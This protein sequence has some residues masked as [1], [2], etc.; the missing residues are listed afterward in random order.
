MAVADSPECC[1]SK[2]VNHQRLYDRLAPFYAPAMRLLPVWLRYARRALPRLPP[3]R[4]RLEIRPRAWW[5]SPRRAWWGPPP[6]GAILEIG[7][8]PGILLAQIAER[9]SCTVGLDL[10]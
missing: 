10:S 6:A 7:P 1:M 5:R 9:Y 8:G 2:Q 3:A 4:A